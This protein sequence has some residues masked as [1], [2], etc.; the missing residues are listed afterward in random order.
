MLKFITRRAGQVITAQVIMD[1]D[2]ALLTQRGERA[3]IISV[4]NFALM[5]RGYLIV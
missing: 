5:A 4:F 3:A 1:P 2:G